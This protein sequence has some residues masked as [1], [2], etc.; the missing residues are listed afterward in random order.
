VVFIGWVLFQKW[1]LCNDD[2]RLSNVQTLT[3]ERKHGPKPALDH[4]LGSAFPWPFWSIFLICNAMP[5]LTHGHSDLKSQVRTTMFLSPWLI[6][7]GRSSKSDFSWLF[8]SWSIGPWK[9][10]FG[11]WSLRLDKIRYMVQSRLFKVIWTI[12]YWTKKNH[13]WTMVLFL[14]RVIYIHRNTKH[15]SEIYLKLYSL[16]LCYFQLTF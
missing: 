11:R 1:K 13:V 7:F 5:D 3:L 16:T 4:G 14:S 6:L 12:V 15:T 2:F 8:G 9:V 10:A